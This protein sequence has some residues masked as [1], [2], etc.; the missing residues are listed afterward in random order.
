MDS[1]HTSSL[2]DQ[3]PMKSCVFAK[4]LRHL[5]VPFDFAQDK[6]FGF[7]PDKPFGLTQDKLRKPQYT[8]SRSQ[9]RTSFNELRNWLIVN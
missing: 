1:C 6:S 3:L 5:Y 2:S 8:V 7:P 9:S 4:C